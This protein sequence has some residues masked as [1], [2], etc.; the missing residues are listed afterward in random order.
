MPK[1]RLAIVFLLLIVILF[2]GCITEQ[3]KTETNSKT[4]SEKDVWY[5]LADLVTPAYY[6]D[7][8]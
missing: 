6:A 8:L 5:G 2:S 7:K 1:T 4:V 3:P